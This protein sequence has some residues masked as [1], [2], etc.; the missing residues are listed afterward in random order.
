MEGT[1]AG[2]DLWLILISHFSVI[3]LLLLPLNHSFRQDTI[4]KIINIADFEIY[5]RIA[6][7]LKTKVE[8]ET[9]H[10]ALK[11]ENEIEKI[12]S[13]LV[14]SVDS[15]LFGYYVGSIVHSCNVKEGLDRIVDYWMDTDKQIS[16]LE[17][18]KE[19]A[20]EQWRNNI[21][22]SNVRIPL[23]ES[24]RRKKEKK[25]KKKSGNKFIKENKTDFKKALASI[26]FT[27]NFINQIIGN[28]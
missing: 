17:K 12:I 26:D 8:S 1:E 28:E 15:F 3:F 20:L 14:T 4:L 7:K 11:I 9:S 2:T 18:E 24:K 25:K 6:D 13:E 27:F 22:H 23:S 19:E 21:T 5:S 16:H 10:E